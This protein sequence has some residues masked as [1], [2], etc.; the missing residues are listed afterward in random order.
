MTCYKIHYA[1]FDQAHDI[2]NGFYWTWFSKSLSPDTLKKFYNEVAKKDLPKEPNQLISDNICGKIVSFDKWKIV[3]RFYNGGNDKHNR[4]DRFVLLTA[5]LEKISPS[6]TTQGNCEPDFNRVFHL[7]I[8]EKLSELEFAKQIPIPPPS[9]DLCEL[10]PS[11]EDFLQLRVEKLE[12]E[13]TFLELQ[14]RAEQG[15]SKSQNEL[16]EYCHKEKHIQNALKWFKKSAEQGN[17]DAQNNLGEYYGDENGLQNDKHESLIWFIRSAK[18]GNAKGQHNFGK[19]LQF[20]FS[21]YDLFKESAEAGNSESQYK[22]GECYETGELAE[23]DTEE[24]KKWYRM[25][26]DNGDTEALK[27]LRQLEGQQ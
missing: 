8:F 23:R 6:D 25:A 9:W 11:N 13:K 17:A 5:W 21:P 14:L 24:A 3:Y 1:L 26:A 16:G 19:C 10:F 4:P 15:D 18:Q 12:K 22:L 20:Y 27:K 7:P 2:E